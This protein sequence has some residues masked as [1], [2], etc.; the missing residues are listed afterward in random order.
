MTPP[1]DWSWGIDTVKVSFDV[2]LSLCDSSSPLWTRSSTQNLRNDRPEA[3]GL[4]GTYVLPQS[5]GG[6]KVVMNLYALD[7]VCHLEFN[8]ARVVSARREELLPPDA[9]GPLVEGVIEQLRPVL[10]PAFVT[11]TPDGEIVW[12]PD[13][14][15][16]VRISRIDLARNF[17]VDDPALIR[18]VL[19][20]VTGRYQ[21]GK[22]VYD[23]TGGG[24]TIEIPTQ[25]VGKDK[26]YNKTAEMSRDPDDDV[27]LR[28][29]AKSLVR[30]E[31]QVLRSRLVS[32]DIK[33]LDRVNA[34]SVWATIQAR[35]DATCWGSPLPVRGDVL[36]ATADL[37]PKDQI[38][39]IGYLH[40]AAVGACANQ[41][42]TTHRNMRKL[43]RKCGLTVGLPVELMG[44]PRT[45]LDL[46]AGAESE[47]GPILSAL[48]A[49]QPAG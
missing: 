22:R 12:A 7:K 21:R 41:T 47:L 25:E 20:V 24:W 33:T 30:F 13:W 23:S 38:T 19:P 4:G 29:M 39:L 28:A 17:E 40:L 26:I 14:R 16:K 43:A 15:S 18:Q 46:W 5:A 34:G 27:R 11:V 9:L 10:W 37:K 45:F 44:R 36:C 42:E 2:D 6:A 49:L 1:Q 31:T 35:W 32:N 8:A 3:E 48:A